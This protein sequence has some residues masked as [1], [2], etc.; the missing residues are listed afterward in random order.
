MSRKNWEKYGHPDGPQGMNIG[1][2]LPSW[3]FNKDRKTAPLMLLAL[4]GG[5]ILLPLAV[6][7]YYMLKGDNYSGPNRIHN[8]TLYAYAATKYGVKESQ[9]RAAV[10]RVGGQVRTCAVLSAPR[11]LCG[12]RGLQLVVPA[13]VSSVLI[14]PRPL[15][16]LK[17]N[18]QSLVR[19]PETLMIAM[20]FI[21]MYTPNDHQLPCDELRKMVRGA[22]GRLSSAGCLQ[23]TVCKRLCRGSCV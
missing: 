18:T 9:V 4:V 10:V 6:V 14:A 21:Q 5:C 23:E 20:E 17:P 3:M 15:T 19:I 12:Y 8:A 7:S 11:R 2:A 13:P 16:Q 22:G 1:V